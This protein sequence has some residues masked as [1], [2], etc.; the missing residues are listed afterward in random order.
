[1]MN[2][3]SDERRGPR[4]RDGFGEGFGPGFGP[5]FG[6]GRPGR[7]HGGRPG[8]GRPG[9]GGP[10]GGRPEGGRGGRRGG[11]R[12]G[13]IRR[14]LLAGLIDGP[15]HGYELMRRLEERSDGRWRPS[16][17]SVYPMLQQLEDEGLVRS[18]QGEGRRAFE[19]TDEGRAQ[20]D[21]AALD[22]LARETDA[23]P[24]SGLR[25]ELEQL[26]LAVRQVRAVGG[27]DQIAEVAGVLRQARQTIYRLL[28]EA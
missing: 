26:H 5:G 18:V 2:D 14:L 19:L 4:E 12:R 23:N 24:G 15:A 3:S 10:E 13:D 27:E 17:G 21:P 28:A 7:R 8:G 25:E 9:G 1:M 16:P 22:E 6:E 20:A 11:R